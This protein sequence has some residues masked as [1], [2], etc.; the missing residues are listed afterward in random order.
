MAEATL[1]Q[2]KKAKDKDS[3]TVSGSNEQSEISNNPSSSKGKVSA[4]PANAGK[5]KTTTSSQKTVTT[6]PPSTSAG[7]TG[8]N[9]ECLLI[10][11]EMNSNIN[12]T[13][14]K[15]EQLT[16]R[17][18]NLYEG[19]EQYFDYEYPYSE[20][21]NNYEQYDELGQDCVSVISSNTDKRSFDEVEDDDEDIFT[22]F[23]KKF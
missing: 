23:I 1:L 2:Q 12:K 11:R 4:N 3:G 16:Q 20:N 22:S 10:L 5:A 15:V 18:D 17:V 21:N 8:F 13:N 7:S 9:Q 19:E 6:P 14:N